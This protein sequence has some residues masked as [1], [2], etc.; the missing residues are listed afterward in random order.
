MNDNEKVSTFLSGG[1]GFTYE[2]HI[3][4]FYLSA[5]LKDGYIFGLNNYQIEKI[6]FQQANQDNP[7]DDF[8]IE[9]SNG[10]QN[11]KLSLQ[12]KHNISFGENEEF[13]NVIRSFAELFKSSNFT[14]GKDKFGIIVG[15]FNK[16]IDHHYK[17]L[18]ELANNTTTPN[19]FETLIDNQSETTKKFYELIKQIL[20]EKQIK[21]IEQLWN[22]CKSFVILYLQHS[23]PSSLNF[24]TLNNINDI[25]QDIEENNHIY[26]AI[27]SITN[28][29]RVSGGSIDK[30]SL[31]IKLLEQ[32]ITIP[33]NPISKTAKD[34]IK[35]RD[36][37]ELALNN[38]KQDIKGITIDRN[39]TIEKI[40]EKL[41]D[42]SSLLMLMGTEGTGK[43]ALLKNLATKYKDEKNCLIF[44]D[45]TI[46]LYTDGGWQGLTNYLKLES[47]LDSIIYSLIANG[48]DLYIFIDGVDF[49]N[50]SGK[51]IMISEIIDTVKTII[52]EIDFTYK[53]VTTGRLNSNVDWLIENI[54]KNNVAIETIDFPLKQ[55]SDF[56]EKLNINKIFYKMGDNRFQP[57]FSN[58]FILEIL[59]N[60]EN[61]EVVSTEWEMV[62][63]WWNNYIVES[64]HKIYLMDFAEKLINNPTRWQKVFD[65]TTSSLLVQNTILIKN[66]YEHYYTRHDIY[67]DWLIALNFDSSYTRDIKFFKTKLQ[68]LDIIYTNYYI[69]PFALFASKLI[70]NK[71]YDEWLDLYEWSVNNKL[72]MIQQGLLESVLSVATDA[73]KLYEFLNSLISKDKILKN[74]L[75]YLY[76]TKIDFKD[77]YFFVDYKTWKPFVCW[78]SNNSNKLYFYKEIHNI[79]KLWRFCYL[80]IADCYF[81]KIADVYKYWLTLS[82]EK[83]RDVRNHHYV[84]YKEDEILRELIF[85]SL[86]KPEYIEEELHKK[87][88]HHD[89]IDVFLLGMCPNILID[90][91]P[92]L[93]AEFIFNNVTFSKEELQKRSE[94]WIYNLSRNETAEYMFE[95]Y[96]LQNYSSCVN[97]K[98]GPFTYFLEKEEDIAI[99]LIQKLTDHAI[100]GL[101]YNNKLEEKPSLSISILGE[102]YNFYGNERIYYWFRP[103][104]I[105]L[106]IMNF[107]FVSLENHIRNKVRQGEDF[108]ILIKKILSSKRKNALASLGIAVSIG[109][110]FPNKTKE[111][112][113]NIATTYE[114]WHMDIQRLAWDRD[115]NLLGTF[116]TQLTEDEVKAF[117]ENKGRK[118]RELHLRDGY[119]H[120]LLADINYRN[121]VLDKANSWNDD[122][123]G[124]IPYYKLQIK[125]L[126][127]VIQGDKEKVKEYHKALLD[128]NKEN[129]S[130]NVN[131]I[132][133]NYIGLGL[134]KDEEIKN[135]SKDELKKIFD[136]I[137]ETYPEILYESMFLSSMFKFILQVFTYKFNLLQ[138]IARYDFCISLIYQIINVDK[139]NMDPIYIPSIFHSLVGILS[140]KIY[141]EFENFNI[142]DLKT[143]YQFWSLFRFRRFGYTRDLVATTLFNTL[144]Q[145]PVR[146][147][148]CNLY[149]N[150]L[151]FILN[152]SVTKKKYLYSNDE[153]RIDQ[154]NK[155]ISSLIKKHSRL[156]KLKLNKIPKLNSEE[157]IIYEDFL[158][159]LLFTSKH[160]KFFNK[161]DRNFYK[162]YLQNLEEVLLWNI[163]LSKIGYE[164]R[165]HSN[166]YQDW[167]EAL[168]KPIFNLRQQYSNDIF[169]KFINILI[170]NKK[171]VPN[172]LEEFI[173]EFFNAKYINKVEYV[174]ILK[175]IFNRILDCEKV[176]SSCG[177][178]F[179]NN[180]IFCSYGSKLL[181]DNWKYYQDFTEIIDKWVYLY[182][183]EWHYYP[184][185]L[186]FIKHYHSH[187][188]LKQILEWLNYIL[189]DGNNRYEGLFEH[190]GND[191]LCIMQLLNKNYGKELQNS[192][193]K[194]IFIDI[195][196][197]LVKCNI[198]TATELQ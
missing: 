97:Y 176:S 130:D 57:L 151:N 52:Q 126:D 143:L 80:L 19:E 5:L 23:E 160:F 68:Q 131:L 44:S 157:N 128:L 2:D 127:A 49:I 123:Y 166:E 10:A 31:I 9:G 28:T 193:L 139:T 1:G 71:K 185:F 114:L 61:P 110:E 41:K 164:E 32:C 141:Y 8:V 81:S 119:I 112:L 27:L 73:K 35:L 144:E 76:S 26:N 48:K 155:R 103:S 4:A 120:Y 111:S 47:T 172:L 46:S 181:E 107:A 117:N 169:D 161:A 165:G 189:Q 133:A 18:N 102:Q 43:S 99:D 64:K 180:I 175:N 146:G 51:K 154:E 138:E 72:L 96:I 70:I 42:N 167:Y 194:R 11:A 21:D 53:I 98:T 108:N 149:I 150:L 147:S 101:I 190:Y 59:A 121:I 106:T 17:K 124:S 173:S 60:L 195:I 34:Y 74:F 197:K 135:I 55:H 37:S 85:L 87:F 67:R 118:H 22:F 156:K 6:S 100:N 152:A 168:Y 33:I 63:L 54:G 12:A 40:K 29:C 159:S 187:Y 184:V 171:Y 129:K 104:C 142:N 170:D 3:G 140:I 84:W 58:L 177:E 179:I 25:A 174:H 69:K 148:K 162:T 158:P 86:Y 83:N 16:N 50:N 178:N 82:R 198:P 113:I 116:G 188:P 122:E 62:K 38:I 24:V 90:K 56:L 66:D 77:K 95:E 30:N 115:I 92:Q 132:S 183:G 192:D 134:K 15:V 14:I 145:L 91:F 88:K 191:T 109:L 79:F 137:E 136:F 45:R 186:C 7:L 89:N 78:L 182:G 94:D 36:F 125:I 65:E 75:D 13:K 163:N 153:Y 105:N 93:Y 196:N 39:K 20:C